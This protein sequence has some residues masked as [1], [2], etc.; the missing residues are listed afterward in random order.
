VLISITQTDF[1]SAVLSQTKIVQLG[2][3]KKNKND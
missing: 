1:W 3:Y 2:G